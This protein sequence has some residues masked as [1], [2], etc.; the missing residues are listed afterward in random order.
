MFDRTS[1][2]ITGHKYPHEDDSH[3][4][5]IVKIERRPWFGLKAGIPIL[6]TMLIDVRGNW[7]IKY[8]DHTTDAPVILQKKLN[9]LWVDYWL[10]HGG[11]I[12]KPIMKFITGR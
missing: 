10:D 8:S 5:V 11:I 6:R 12:G 7:F 2:K 1:V 3:M 9:D 4:M